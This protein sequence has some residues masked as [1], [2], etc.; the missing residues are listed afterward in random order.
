MK[1][2]LKYLYIC[3]LAGELEGYISI[4]PGKYCRCVACRIEKYMIG[5]KQ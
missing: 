5:V 1:P 4:R 2:E 3:V